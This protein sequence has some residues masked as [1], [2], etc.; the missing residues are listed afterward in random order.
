MNKFYRVIWSSA[1]LKWIVVSEFSGGKEKSGVRRSVAVSNNKKFKISSRMIA[2]SI[3]GLVC[4][5]FPAIAE[6]NYMGDIYAVSPDSVL[7]NPLYPQF[8]VGKNNVVGSLH[9]DTTKN[10]TSY[11]V[12]LLASG[13]DITILDDVSLSSEQSWGNNTTRDLAI[14]TYMNDAAIYARISQ[15]DITNNNKVNIWGKIMVLAKTDP[16]ANPLEQ[17]SSVNIITSDNS[18]FQGVT[19]MYNAGIPGVRRQAESR[20]YSPAYGP[21]I[22]LTFNGKNSRWDMNGDS[23]L[24]NLTLKDATLNFMEGRHFEGSVIGSKFQYNYETEVYEPLPF[25]GQNGGNYLSLTKGTDFKTLLVYGDYHGDNG[26]IIM[27]TVLGDD[28]SL[29]DRMVVYGDTS[30]TTNVVVRNAGGTGA[31][32]LEG[33]ELITVLG[34]SAG[35]FRQNGRIVAGAY[36]YTL[37]RGQ[38]EKDKNW[39]LTSALTPVPPIDPEPEAPAPEQPDTP[40]TEPE[41]PAPEQPDTPVQGMPSAPHN[42]TPAPREHALRPEASL[43]GMNLA[44]ANTLFSTR[45]HDRLGE[46]HYV[47]ALTGEKTVTSMW[48]RNV[49]GHTRQKDSSGQLNMQANRYVMQLGGDI[50]QWS[51]DSTNRFHLGLMAGYANQKGRAE[52]RR[53]NNKADSSVHGYSIGLYGTWLQDSVTLEG[54]YADSWAQYSWFDNTVSGR[55]VESEKYDSQGFTVSV[56]SG[57]TWKLADFSKRTALYIQPKAQVTWMGVKAD[58]HRE[59]NGTRVES[60]GDGN[61]QSRVGVRLYGRGHSKL[62]EG[63]GRTFQPFIEANWIHNTR[64]F[65]VSMNDENVKL[66]GDR[67]AG[68]LKGGVEGQLTKHV[69]LWGNVSQQ[70]GDQG[71]SDTSAMLGIK[72]SF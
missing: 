16:T 27:N 47:D 36:D 56:E 61:I 45:L 64:D 43:Y 37:L 24:T 58:T 10:D 53:N 14:S 54:A 35:E 32:T 38:G 19:D 17:K 48:L 5:T 3:F 41:A 25:E 20:T 28:N 44:A 31:E 71:Y 26:N 29:T 72:A 21:V 8:E 6:D 13:T 11:E 52:N 57:Y 60:Q 30:G 63:K 33:I 67:H 39:Y 1:L 23:E 59:A 40:V 46:T 55:G 7:S 69:A 34:T 49:G 4:T 70:V 66:V 12:Y 65:G 2:L 68:E 9:L 62:D 22:N 51:S 50:A 18:Y 42:P 15:V